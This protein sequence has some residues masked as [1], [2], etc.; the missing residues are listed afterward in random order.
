MCIRLGG[1]YKIYEVTIPR[2]SMW[3]YMVVN[4]LVIRIRTLESPMKGEKTS[5]T[6]ESKQ[7]YSVMRLDEKCLKNLAIT[8]TP[9]FNYNSSQKWIKSDNNEAKNK[10]RNGTRK[11]TN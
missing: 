3:P 2:V 9:R 7:F 10:E 1:W 11:S 5:L 4:T 6:C 8:M